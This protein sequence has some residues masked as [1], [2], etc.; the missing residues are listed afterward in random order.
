MKARS[1]ST[2]ATRPATRVAPSRETTVMSAREGLTDRRTG[3][4][5]SIGSWLQQR[6]RAHQPFA[7]NARLVHEINELDRSF[8]FTPV[9]SPVARSRHPCVRGNDEGERV[10][11]S[12]SVAGRRQSNARRAMP[13]ALEKGRSTPT[14][15]C[16]RF[17][18]AGREVGAASAAP[19]TAVSHQ[20]QLPC[21][22]CF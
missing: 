3:V 12:A 15:V 22:D 21:S 13:P 4:L 19:Q 7:E 9:P 2:A 20:P 1:F 18:R 17:Q 11:P 14:D 6:N 10:D 8:T 16:E 5:S